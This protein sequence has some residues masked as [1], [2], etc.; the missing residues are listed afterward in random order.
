VC[1]KKINKPLV[2]SSAILL[3]ITALKKTSL[4]QDGGLEASRTFQ[5]AQWL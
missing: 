4:I 3:D 5:A 1:I 2:H